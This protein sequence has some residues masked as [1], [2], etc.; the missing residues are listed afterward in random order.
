MRVDTLICADELDRYLSKWVKIL[1]LEKWDIRARITRA[2]KMNLDDCAGENNY[3]KVDRQSIIHLRDPNDWPCEDFSYDME[4]VLVHELLHLTFS[5][6]DTR[7]GTIDTLQHR[8]I[9]DL[10]VAL[11]KANREGMKDDGNSRSVC[12]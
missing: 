12:G 3:N 1:G 7:G 2:D 6:L 5:L 4:K 11:V 10:A 8:I 9:N